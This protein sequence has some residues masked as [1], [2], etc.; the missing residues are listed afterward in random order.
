MNRDFATLQIVHSAGGGHHPEDA[1]WGCVYEHS[2]TMVVADGASVR[3]SPIKSLQPMLDKYAPQYTSQVTPSGVA[4]RLIRDT[5]AQLAGSFPLIP[6]DEMIL[7]ANQR[8]ADELTA[9]YGELSAAAILKHEPHLTLLEEEARYLR[10][11]LPVSTYA[12][13]RADW[14]ANT[15]EVVQGADAAVF[16]LYQDGRCLQITPD[17]MAQHDEAA[18]KNLV[19]QPDAPAQ[20]PFFR[21]MGDNRSSEVNRLNGIYHNYVGPD[22]EID[23][24]LGV[25]V[26]DGLP[27][28]AN[29][30]FQTQI[31]LDGIQAVLVTSDGMFWPS[32]LDETPDAASQRIQAMGERITRDGIEG[33]LHALRAEETHL[34][35]SGIDPHQK[36]DDATGLLLTLGK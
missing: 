28:I 2:A 7:Q 34:R 19:G 10:L 5:V 16:I 1:G 14:H 33:Y 30:M 4:S 20:H 31:S 36:H 13:A 15:L 17:Q 24:S 22:G 3:L 26:V 9:I 6:L 8:L 12:V 11:A 21:Q 25:S 18:R 32:P 27:Q 29:Y 23:Q 35:E